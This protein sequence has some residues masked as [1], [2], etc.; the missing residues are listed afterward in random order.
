MKIYTSIILFINLTAIITWGADTNKAHGNSI[1]LYIENDSRNIGG[2]GSDQAY[3][4]GFRISYV[5]SEHIHPVLFKKLINW[6]DYLKTELHKSKTNFSISLAHQ[7][8]SPNKISDE[9]LIANDRPYAGWLNLGLAVHFKNEN[10]DHLL[11][12]NLGLIGPEAKGKEVQNSFHR[13]I[14]TSEGKGWQ[15][16]LHSEPTLQIYYQQRVRFFEVFNLGQKYFE[17]IPYYGSGFGNVA[18]ESHIGGILR[19]GLNLPDDFGPTRNSAN[20]GD[21]IVTAQNTITR[22]ASYYIFSGAKAIG[23]ARNIFLDG[24]TFQKSHSVNKYP[25]IFETDFGIG[26]KIKR[27]DLVW[28]FVTK[29][30]EFKEQSRFNSFAS[31]SFSYLF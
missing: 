8:Y 1:N 12:L 27:V 2:P 28:R 31:I 14:K 6:S 20:D 7:I 15:N 23:V 25:L 4:N 29:S 21:K 24:N 13:L 17:I 22:Y 11:S 16:Q 19:F 5:M 3:S 30:P 9:N 18:I 10:H 26:L